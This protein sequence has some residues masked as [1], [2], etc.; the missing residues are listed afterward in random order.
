MLTGKATMLLSTL[1][2]SLVDLRSECW[3]E[4]TQEQLKRLEEEQ[5]KLESLLIAENK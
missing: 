5:G 2:E 4:E 3:T 1:R